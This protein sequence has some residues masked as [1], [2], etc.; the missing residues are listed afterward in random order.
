MKIVL[1]SNNKGKINEFKKLLPND[2]VIA[3][4]EI[5]GKF[6]VEEDKDTF[7]GNAIKKAQTIYDELQKK[8]FLDVLVISDDSGISV[9]ALNNE[10]GVYSARYAGLNANDKENNQKLICELNKLKLEITPAFYTAC[11][12]IV[13]NKE[14]YTVHGFMYGKV[15]NKELGENGFGYDPMFIPNGFSKTLGELDFEVKQEFSHRNRAL[16]LAK[17]VLDVIL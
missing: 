12:A 1:A 7:K 6:E 3:F 9:P 16:K 5:L 15:I 10:P 14:V 17:K 13:Y 2:E 4:N 11:I 8:G